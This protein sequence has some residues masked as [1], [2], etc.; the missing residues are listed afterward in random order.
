MDPLTLALI[1]GG[2]TLASA[3]FNS[4]AQDQV[5][6]ARAAVQ[7]KDTAQQAALDAQAKTIT[8][9]SLA[10]FD[11]FGAQQDAEAK[12]LGDFYNTPITTATT[13]NTT[14][15]LPA[16]TNAV[17]NREIATKNGI[18]TAFGQQQGTALGK[19]Q[20]FGTLM[21]NMNRSQAADD[22][23]VGEIGNFKQGDT[24]V[25][26][27]ALNNANLA[28]DTDATIGNLL[29]GAG[30][31]ALTAGLSGSLGTGTL[32]GNASGGTAANPIPGLTDAD[33]GPGATLAD[34]YGM[35]G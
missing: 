3:F 9:G 24:A 26:K 8:D 31:V 20:S 25:T 5:N 33:Y 2:S 29:G 17:V 1:G 35:S 19:L 7:A 6:A 23:A 16:S 4:N 10:R 21:G 32:F 11:N 27:I 12:T 30:K 28:G 13:P 22:Q 15:P 14:A 34:Q 18:A